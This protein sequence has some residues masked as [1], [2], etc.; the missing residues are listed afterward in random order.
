MPIHE[1]GSACIE[2]VE[3]R[4]NEA[5]EVEAAGVVPSTIDN[6]P[7]WKAEGGFYPWL[8][9]SLLCH[10][11][12]FSVLG[13]CCWRA[14]GG[15]AGGDMLARRRSKKPCRSS[16]SFTDNGWACA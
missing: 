7:T 5:D 16:K 8:R 11:L 14:S 1:E 10:F 15:C 9:V 2:Q 3:D 4:V 12:S 6:R 13:R